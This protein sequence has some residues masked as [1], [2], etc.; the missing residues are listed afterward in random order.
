[1][2]GYDSLTSP[3][4]PAKSTDQLPTNAPSSPFT[5]THP[6]QYPAPHSPPS[7][8]AYPARSYTKLNPSRPASASHP[9]PFMA[10]SCGDSSRRHHGATP[11]LS[12]RA[13]S[14]PFCCEPGHHRI[15]RPRC[16]DAGTGWGQWS[17]TP[18]AGKDPLIPPSSPSSSFS[19]SS[20]A[21]AD[22]C[23][24][25]SRG[26][27]AKLRASSGEHEAA[28]SARGTAGSARVTGSGS[29]GS[30]GA[31]A[32]GSVAAPW[33]KPSPPRSYPPPAGQVARRANEVGWTGGGSFRWE[34]G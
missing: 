20:V 19:S 27:G 29:S 5:S 32:A 24:W 22:V 18:P 15:G 17:P 12:P 33:E 4:S 11:S 8:S 31:A 28:G 30:G 26:A 2:M 10:R 7:S 13:Y 21:V 14:T 23:A 16:P 34:R 1:M 6:R 3:G 9:M 25:R